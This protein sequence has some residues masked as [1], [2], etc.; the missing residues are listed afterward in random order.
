M[1]LQDLEPTTGMVFSLHSLLLGESPLKALWLL[2]LGW[3]I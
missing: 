1:V 2:P 3:M